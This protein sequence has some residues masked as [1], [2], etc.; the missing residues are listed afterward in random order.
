MK[1]KRKLV[2]YLCI[3]IACS[4]LLSA[5]SLLPGKKDSADPVAPAVS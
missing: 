1:T 4:V 5:C 2:R 3:L